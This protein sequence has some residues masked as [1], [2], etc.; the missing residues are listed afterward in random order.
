MNKILLT[1]LLLFVFALSACGGNGETISIDLGKGVML[2]MVKIPAG[3]FQMGEEPKFHSNEAPIHKV[4]ISKDFYMGKYEVTQGQWV[5]IMGS[6]PSR[7]KNGDSYPVEQVSWDDIAVNGF[8]AKINVKNLVQG[9]FRLPTEAEWEY[10]CRA[11]SS[12]CFY[13]GDEKSDCVEQYCW[14]YDNAH[15]GGLA[16]PHATQDGTQ[17]VGS[18]LP[19]LF[20]LYDMSGNVSEW[21]S[22]YY[23]DY[24][25]GVVTNPRG[26][27]TGSGRII[28]G[29]NWC[30]DKWDC[31]SA[32]RSNENPSGQYLNFG[33]R[34]AFSP[35]Q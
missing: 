27:A 16:N 10:A 35:K 3:T 6:N 34:L 11:R 13:W 19:N 23:G 20:G 24:L 2:E 28:R 9:I 26:P 5:E 12:T 29:G 21:C 4:K 30:R 7:F 14:Y 8:L 25:P 32:R 17:P 15:E 31:R 18:K 33:F 22:D 1:I